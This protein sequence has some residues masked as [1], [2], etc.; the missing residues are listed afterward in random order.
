QAAFD[1]HHPAKTIPALLQARPLVAAIKD[2]WAAIKLAELDETVALCAGLWLDAAP[3]RWDATPG[4]KVAVRLTALN[5]SQVPLSLRRV[6]LDGL[7]GNG[8]EEAGAPLA[9]NK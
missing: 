5:R 1:P 8:S 4:G 6:E 9:Y 3:A 7:G 2:P